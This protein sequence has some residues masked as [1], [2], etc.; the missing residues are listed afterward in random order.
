L[1]LFSQYQQGQNDSEIPKFDPLVQAEEE[2]I[3]R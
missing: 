1:Y 3:S 2:K